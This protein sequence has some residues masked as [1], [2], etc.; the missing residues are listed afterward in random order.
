MISKCQCAVNDSHVLQMNVSMT[1]SQIMFHHSH[2]RILCLKNHLLAYGCLGNQIIMESSPVISSVV[3]FSSSKKQSFLQLN[4]L[5]RK[6]L[7][8][9]TVCKAC[10]KRSWVKN[11]DTQIF[12][13]QPFLNSGTKNF[14]T[15]WGS[16]KVDE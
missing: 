6:H 7:S 9:A 16:Q 11:F 8:V 13:L 14:K 1:F 5:K 3:I 4:E 15:S 2:I 12:L 10:R